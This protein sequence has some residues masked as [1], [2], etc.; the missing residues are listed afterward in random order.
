MPR[1]GDICQYFNSSVFRYYLRKKY[2]THKTFA[3]RMGVSF[4]AVYAWGSGESKP[5]WKHLIKMAGIFG[6]SARRLITPKKR[7]VLDKWEDHLLDYLEAPPE[8]KKQTKVETRIGDKDGS[9]THSKTDTE[10]EL[11]LSE[12]G[13]IELTEKLGIFED[14]TGDDED[15]PDDRLEDFQA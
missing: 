11:K 15:E 6:I 9:E 5:T 3:K 10:R 12:K 7:Y 14:V 2:K 13:A 4:Q 1:R 8:V